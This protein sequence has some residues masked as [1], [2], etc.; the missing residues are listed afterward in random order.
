MSLPQ[1]PI[2]QSPWWGEAE[3]D[4][5]VQVGDVFDNGDIAFRI[6]GTPDTSLEIL[7]LPPAERCGVPAV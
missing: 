2:F 4:V 1:T 7:Q 6:T 5:D 3:I